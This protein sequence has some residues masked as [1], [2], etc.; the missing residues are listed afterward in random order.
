MDTWLA[1]AAESCTQKDGNPPLEEIDADS[2]D[3]P[4]RT[5]ARRNLHFLWDG[6]SRELHS[7]AQNRSS[8]HCWLVQTTPRL[9]FSR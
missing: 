7:F 3:L 2:S 1:D 9:T 4:V 8:G 5:I 6:L